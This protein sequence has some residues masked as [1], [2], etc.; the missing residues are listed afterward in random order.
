LPD[1]SA[2]FSPGIDETAQVT[3]VTGSVAVFEAKAGQRALCPS[4]GGPGK[5]LI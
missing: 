3:D 4:L 2:R 1:G 5:Q